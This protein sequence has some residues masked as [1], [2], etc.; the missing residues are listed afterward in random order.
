VS[1]RYVRAV[2]LSENLTV[3]FP[4]LIKKTKKPGHGELGTGNQEPGFDGMSLFASHHRLL[5]EPERLHR[6]PRKVLL[7]ISSRPLQHDNAGFPRMTTGLLLRW[8]VD[9]GLAT[10][11]FPPLLFGK[12]LARLFTEKENSWSAQRLLHSLVSATFAMG[13]VVGRKGRDAILR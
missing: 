1:Y 11:D 3:A 12:L 5:S 8:P 13:R 2:L 9:V 10:L 7:T 4:R 6:F